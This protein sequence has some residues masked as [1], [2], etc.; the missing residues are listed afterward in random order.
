MTLDTYLFRV[1]NKT[2]FE[3]G[4]GSWS[5]F[6]AMTVRTEAPPLMFDVPPRGLWQAWTLHAVFGAD[7]LDGRHGTGTLEEKAAYA[8]EVAARLERFCSGATSLWACLDNGDRYDMAFDQDRYLVAGSRYGRQVGP[9]W[10][11]LFH[12]KDLWDVPT[13]SPAHTVHAWNRAQG[14]VV[15]THFAEGQED[16]ALDYFNYITEDRLNSSSNQ[17]IQES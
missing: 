8:E 6:L 15:T 10:L 2:A 1:D 13:P 16:A 3:L 12:Q 9:W 17:P 5:F 7:H 4:S 11:E 14:R